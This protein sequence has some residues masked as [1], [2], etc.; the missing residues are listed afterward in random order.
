MSHFFDI[1]TISFY[2]LSVVINYIWGKYVEHFQHIFIN[3]HNWIFVHFF[4]TISHM[5]YARTYA[6]WF[7]CSE[8]N[9]TGAL[10]ITSY[11]LP[12]CSLP[13]TC[14]PIK[15]PVLKIIRRNLKI[16]AFISGH[17]VITISV[18]ILYMIHLVH[19]LN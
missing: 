18:V 15:S 19:S 17:E 2:K 8:E 14:S 3:K 10:F 9:L 4:K 13:F 7:R 12:L 5:C 11:S 1:I 16:L 6:G